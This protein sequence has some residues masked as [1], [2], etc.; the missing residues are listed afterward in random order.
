MAIVIVVGAAAWVSI[1]VCVGLL[2]GQM[3][4]LP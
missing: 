3:I 1:A 4:K 2:L